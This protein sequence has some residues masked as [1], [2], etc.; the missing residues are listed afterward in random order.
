MRLN[1]APLLQR[2]YAL[3]LLTSKVFA[4]D[5][6]MLKIHAVNIHALLLNAM[7]QPCGLTGPATILQEP[8]ALRA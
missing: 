7:H 8:S 1:L 2:L 3:S 5:R 6:H 4:N